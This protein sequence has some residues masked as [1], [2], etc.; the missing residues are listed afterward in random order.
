MS[1]HKP[2]STKMRTSGELWYPELSERLW[3]QSYSCA[4]QPFT[5]ADS[6]S[7]PFTQV[8]TITGRTVFQFFMA[9]PADWT[10]D[11]SLK[12]DLKLRYA[13]YLGID[14]TGSST[15]DALVTAR[16]SLR[17]ETSLTTT[18]VSANG[19]VTGVFTTIPTGVQEDTLLMDVGAS[20]GDP[21]NEVGVL[22]HNSDCGCYMEFF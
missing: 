9:F 1:V 21:G 8:G 16:F 5:V 10:F 22:S 18:G 4:S 15:N 13:F 11:T 7:S 6:M 3:R 20:S 12:S 17:P 19:V 2:I 14:E